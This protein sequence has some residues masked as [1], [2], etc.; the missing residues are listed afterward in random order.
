MP[1][2]HTPIEQQPIAGLWFVIVAPAAF[3]SI[4]EYLMIFG[5][6]GPLP[7]L[8]VLAAVAFVWG[9]PWLLASSCFEEL[10]RRGAYAQHVSPLITGAVFTTL[11]QALCIAIAFVGVLL[12]GS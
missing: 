9:L 12:F 11:I 6:P 4:L 2:H 5:T 7:V 1:G 8:P 3:A 10:A